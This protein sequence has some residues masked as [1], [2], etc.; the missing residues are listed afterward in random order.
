MDFDRSPNRTRSRPKNDHVREQTC[1]CVSNF[2]FG[3][4]IWHGNRKLHANDA[5]GHLLRRREVV[6]IS[7]API[8]MGQC[9]M[10]YSSASLRAFAHSSGVNHAP[11]QLRRFDWRGAAA[12]NVHVTRTVSNG[13]VNWRGLHFNVFAGGALA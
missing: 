7:C 6:G 4:I 3:V 10:Q 13:V 1:G 12:R 9:W 5:M 2:P 8:R 11:N